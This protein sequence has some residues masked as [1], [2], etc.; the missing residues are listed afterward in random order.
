MSI[1][2]IQ[3]R[4]PIHSLFPDTPNPPPLWL[5]MVLQQSPAQASLPV[6]QEGTQCPPQQ[7]SPQRHFSQEVPRGPGASE[8][9]EWTGAVSCSGLTHILTHIH[10]HTLTHTH[11]H[12]HTHTHTHIL[13]HS[14]TLTYTLSCTDTHMCTHTHTHTYT[15]TH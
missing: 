1:T 15:H 6:R 10:S 11:T 9:P 4:T 7:P 5:E 14:H 12:I 2:P 8:D 3:G 13:T